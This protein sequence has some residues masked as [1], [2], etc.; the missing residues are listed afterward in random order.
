[1][2]FSVGRGQPP[3]PLPV[4]QPGAMTPPRGGSVSTLVRQIDDT[5][6]ANANG[7]GGCDAVGGVPLSPPLAAQNIAARSTTPPRSPVD[8]LAPGGQTPK[9]KPPPL[10][11]FRAVGVAARA[12][13]SAGGRSGG[14]GGQPDERASLLSIAPPRHIGAEPSALMPAQPGAPATGWPLASPPMQQQPLPEAPPREEERR[15][16]PLH[17]DDLDGTMR[18]IDAMSRELARKAQASGALGGTLEEQLQAVHEVDALHLRLYGTSLTQPAGAEA[19][20]PGA[21]KKTPFDTQTDHL[22]RQARDKHTKLTKER[23]VF[24]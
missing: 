1:M 16:A 11:P 18:W 2:S 21:G 6:A 14:G 5:A 10:R 22:P 20:R 15:V 24:L 13:R 9:R 4:V 19:G 7:G 12:V 23:C 8:A 3:P 17:A